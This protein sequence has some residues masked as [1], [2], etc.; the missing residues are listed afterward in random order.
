[1]KKKNEIQRFYA[2]LEDRMKITKSKDVNII[3]GNFNAKV[4]EGCVSNL[5]GIYGLG[6][7]N[8]RG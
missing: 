2:E 6:D 3:L 8:E 4:G 1:M 7:Q 5:V